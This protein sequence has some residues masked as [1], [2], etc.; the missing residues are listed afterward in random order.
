MAAPTRRSLAATGTGGS[1]GGGGG[2]TASSAEADAAKSAVTSVAALIVAAAGL[3]LKLEV[4]VERSSLAEARQ[5]LWEG[6]L[7]PELK[8]RLWAELQLTGSPCRAAV[9]RASARHQ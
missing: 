9:A 1:G 6:L 4:E 3:Q 2:A 8:V 7:V 5:S